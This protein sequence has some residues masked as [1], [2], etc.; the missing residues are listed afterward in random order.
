MKSI[1]PLL[2]ITIII[3]FAWWAWTEG[4]RSGEAMAE[5]VA[6][7]MKALSVY[8]SDMAIIERL[9]ISSCSDSNNNGV[10]KIPR[11]EEEP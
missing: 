5:C 7:K 2:S 3:L 6:S 1:G 9:S 8:M 4:D 11:G 10:V